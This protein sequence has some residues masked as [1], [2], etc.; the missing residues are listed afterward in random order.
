MKAKEVQVVE[1]RACKNIN[2]HLGRG[3]LL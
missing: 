3:P 1:R 2:M